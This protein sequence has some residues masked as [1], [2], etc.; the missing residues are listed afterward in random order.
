MSY[1]KHESAYV[2][3]GCESP[4]FEIIELFEELGAD[5]S[6]CDPYIPKARKVRRHNL[7]LESVPCPV[8]R[9]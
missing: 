2:D 6:Y 5:V 8:V 3:D 7:K 1:F 9:A 4:S